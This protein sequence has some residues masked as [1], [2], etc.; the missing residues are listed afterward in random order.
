MS[1]QAVRF[2]EAQLAMFAADN[3]ARMDSFKDELALAAGKVTPGVDDTPYIQYALEA[4]TRERGSP[5]AS[6]L[7]VPSPPSERYSQGFQQQ[8]PKFMVKGFAPVPASKGEP[9]SSHGAMHSPISHQPQQPKPKD[10]PQ[11]RSFPFTPQQPGPAA[12]P[13]QQ[14]PSTTHQWIPV[15]KNMLQTIDPRGRT[16]PALTFKPRILRPFSLLMLMILCAIM[17]AGL[18]FSGVYSQKNDGL[19]PYP[20]SIYSGQYFVFRILPQILAGIIL[21][22]AQ[23]IVTASLRVVPFATL[24]QEDPEKRY[25]ALFQNLYATSFLLP[26]LPG[27]W[28]L[29]TFGIATW[30]ANF[31]LPLLSA[32]FTCIYVDREGRWVWSATQGLVWASVALY[33]ILLVAAGILMTFW[34]GHWTGLL[35]DARS[36]AD[37]IPLLH[38]TNTMSSYRRKGLY[39]R[40][41]DYRAELRERWFDRLGY[42]Q[43]RDSVGGVWHAIGTSAVPADHGPDFVTE[44][45]SERRSNELSVGSH[46][47]GSSALLDFEGGKYLPWCLRDIPL[48]SFVLV[49]SALLLALLIVSFLPQTKLES[50]F[51]PLLPSRPDGSAFSAANFLY[52]FLPSTLGMILFLLF[53]SFDQALRILQP[54]GDMASLDGAVA[55]R[56][57]LADYAACL[58]LHVTARALRNG[59]WRVAVI[60]LMSTLFI[61]IPILAGG[62]FMALTTPSQQVRMFPSMPVFGV[63]LAFLVLYVGCASLLIPQRRQFYLPHCVTTIASLISFCTAKDLYED[64]AFRSVRSRKDLAA[65]LGVGRKDVR[66]ES[67]WFFGVLAGR[68]EK[69][70]SVRR[71]RRYTEKVAMTRSMASMV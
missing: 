48:V 11:D 18:I 40:N 7:P 63:L 30:L 25:L 36:I 10:L 22:Y 64:P 55:S 69:R 60:S 51:T 33:F 47:T 68:D 29:K 37:V 5:T 15:D 6:Q 52:S 2:D 71:M 39:E 43:N 17:M 31:T 35:W 57:I 38:R 34:F 26:Q 49:T 9:S 53:Q 56:S 14:K 67:L 8:G 62:L 42:W 23:S 61:F 50:G 41:C 20:G 27:A 21:I 12:A 28:Q 65:R 45:R 58:P 44:P 54:W 32:A 46:L 70:I 1:N 59:H 19:T 66:E 3:A 16:Y 24:A 4:L 13:V